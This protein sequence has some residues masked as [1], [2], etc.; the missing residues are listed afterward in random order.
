MMAANH[1]SNQAQIIHYKSSRM[2][3][4]MLSGDVCNNEGV[5]H[6]TIVTE[7]GRVIAA[8]HSVVVTDIRETQGTEAPIFQFDQESITKITDNKKHQRI[9]IYSR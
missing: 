8:Y 2:M 6:P 9:E 7:S 1:H 4:C 5:P 3:P